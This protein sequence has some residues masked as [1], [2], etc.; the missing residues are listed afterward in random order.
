MR[1]ARVLLFAVLAALSATAPARAAGYEVG[2][3]HRSL[4]PTQAQIDSGEV[5]LG[6]Y[7]VTGNP[8]IGDR[9]A[10][11]ILG[12]GPTVGAFAVTD[13]ERGA[14]VVA[15]M[16]VQG[17]FAATRDGP[18]GIVDMRRAAA[19]A[20]GLR[21]DQIFIQ[22]DHSHS[23]A[24]AMGVWG[25]VPLAF[26]KRMF[27]QTVEAI[28]AAYDQRAPA[29]ELVYGTVGAAELLN[30]QFDYDPDNAEMDDEVRV[31]QARDEH[32]DA[33]AS[34]VNFS[35]HTTVLGASNT[36]IS[37]DWVQRADPLIADAIG[38]EV[39][40]MVG[41]LGRSQPKVRDCDVP[42][43]T[44]ED[45][46]KLDHYAGLVRDKVQTALAD[47]E[48]LTGPATVAAR[49]Y[50]IQD[51]SSNPFLLGLLYAG[52][53]LDAPLNRSLEPPWMTGNVVGTTTG[54]ALIGDVLVSSVPGEIYPQIARTVRDAV[55]SKARGFMTL[56]LS[57]DQLG[58]IIAPFPGAYVKPICATVFEDCADTLPLEPGA[59]P[60]DN[61]L[62][63]ASPT[64]GERVICSLLRGADEVL[65]TTERGERTSCTPF[66][67]DGA[68]PEAADTTTPADALDNTAFT[69]S[70]DGPIRAGVG[71]A[72]ASWHVGASAGQ[73]AST[74][75]D[76]DPNGEIDP[77]LLQL[78]NLP[79]YGL[80]SRLE[81][82]ALVVEGSD[83]V[84]H[85]I[86]KNDLYIPQDLLWR[87][88]AQI[89]A[90]GDS[91]ITQ[92]TLTVASTHDHSSPYYS[93]TGAGAWTFQ[94]VFDVRFFEYYAQQMAKAVEAAADSLQP[95]RIG[96][97]VGSLDKVH[98][99]SFGPATADDGTPAGYPVADADHDLTV[100]RVDTADGKPLG[101][102]VNYS[103]H[104]EGND[105]NDLISADW[106]APLE[107][108]VDRETG[109]MMVFTQNA[110]GTA[111]PERS[112]YHDPS[113]RLEFTH[114][115][116]AQLEYASRL[117]A[118]ETK[119]VWEEVDS[120]AARVP[121]ASEMPIREADRWYPGPLSHPVPTVSNCRFDE[122]A[123]PVAGLPDCER[124][125]LGEQDPGV[126]AALLKE[127]GIPVPENVSAPSYG[128]LEED[129]SV[130]MQALRLG[131]IVLTMCSCE[132]WADQARNIKT[133]TDKA[134]GNQYL[135][136][137]WPEAPDEEASL[138]YRRMRAQIANDAV[139]WDFLENVP[140]A[141]S[142]PA[143]PDAIRGNYTHEELAPAI[144]YDLTVPLSMTN[145]YNGYIAT[146]REYQRGDHYRKALTAWGPHSSDYFATRLV[147]LAGHLK[148][149]DS[150]VLA[151]E[152]QRELA[153]SFGRAKTE[154]DQALNDAKA[155]AFGEAGREGAAAYA[156]T[157]PDDG[158]TPGAVSEPGDIER[159]GA[160][161]FTWRGGSNFTDDPR[162]TVQRRLG[163]DW[164][165]YADQSGEVPVTVRFPR[166]DDDGLPDYAQGSFEWKWTATF[167]AFVSPFDTGARGRATPPGEYRFVVH[168]RHRTGGAVQDYDV[169]S[170]TFAV[171]PWSGITSALT[172][173]DDGTLAVAVPPLD[174]PDSYETEGK[175]RFI[176]L[177]PTEIGGER[178]CFTCT[179]R[180]WLDTG[181]AET[182][183]VTITRA[184]GSTETVPAERDGDRWRTA[185]KL[186][187]G[188]SATV[189]AGG[190]LDAW[191]NR[192]GAPSNVVSLPATEPSP[193][194]EA[195]STPTPASTPSPAPA[196]TGTPSPVP[197]TPE[198][199]A[200]VIRGTGRNDRLRGT[201]RSER[202][203]GRGGDD[204]LR[205]GRGPDCLSG[206]RGNDRVTGNGGRDRMRGGPGDDRLFAAGSARDVLDCG[207]GRDV[208]V[209]D[210]HDVTRHC[211]VVRRR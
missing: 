133:R 13:D 42:G 111:E 80:Q 191:A 153:D 70:G 118:D 79:S 155:Q 71:K 64:L 116:Y 168:G 171:S 75:A 139:G 137:Q 123:V 29:A 127:A 165:D 52:S 169:A 170:R 152:A 18:Y 49:S 57:G 194:P 98:R 21:A 105:G 124:V 61:Y 58:Y 86:V 22:S 8:A 82:R 138:P 37:G 176:T 39:V 121:F 100:V 109:A 72:D 179:F 148:T 200:V 120:P 145:D 67:N 204:R 160:A 7:G 85:A 33:I 50:L 74:K 113:E 209:V 211:E 20:T 167:E 47:A 115:N 56:G 150:P 99:H 103:L 19:A 59:L 134:Q 91:G 184:D 23:G 161:L 36:R 68:M 88:T 35:A 183:T 87:R 126:S 5:H 106:V 45:L 122:P 43:A 195:S 187:P 129:V 197:A 144:G 117:I 202:I 32:G 69:G 157:L 119:R 102:L 6:G 196:A 48:P 175:A 156:D 60:N 136:Y 10:T 66:A 9:V 78:K 181:E 207:P 201:A 93:S 65:G 206:G 146:Y 107:R 125:P 26:R 174:Y 185:A 46:C 54:T 95:A 193:V 94:D 182:V 76:A 162:V 92:Q 14:V 41:T 110:V 55:G 62:F 172:L 151:T 177:E 73:Y 25:G 12:D 131:E 205:G 164:V 114:R 97:S 112:T 31:L 158:G 203:R 140:T 3:A 154:A 28:T 24:D 178:Y 16:Q 188:D 210:R 51:A 199:C 11:G 192:N 4:N 90:E 2:A 101:M 30:N 1:G 198:R 44:D 77:S 180:P 132:Q 15:D 147:Q 128:A 34:L 40:T 135:G 27:E 81:A 173:E 208:A 89:L 149:P 143:D 166:G 142:E 53:A 17:W 83:G 130:H 163:G 96:A 104:G 186:G 190:V 159:F 38:G 84:R 63:N 108:M 189:A 141:E